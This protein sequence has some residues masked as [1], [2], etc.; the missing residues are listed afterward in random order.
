MKRQATVFLLTLLGAAGCGSTRPTDPGDTG[1]KA[2]VLAYF[3]GI[4]RKDWQSVYA[5]LTPETQKKFSPQRFESQAKV[6]R[7]RIG[8]EPEDVHIR[9]CEENGNDAT[10][11]VILLTK[12]PTHKRRFVDG[13]TAKRIEGQ[14]R[15]VLPDNYGR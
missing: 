9:S 12:N 2:A 1:S 7:L 8:F 13:I 3:Q 10:A 14:W 11:H 15:I 5:M 4:L 6:T